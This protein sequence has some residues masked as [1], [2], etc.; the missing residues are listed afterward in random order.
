MRE[1][2][3][4]RAK[5]QA[6]AMPYFGADASAGAKPLNKRPTDEKQ[7]IFPQRTNSIRRQSQCSTW[8]IATSDRSM[9]QV[10]HW[11]A[12]PSEWRM[13]NRGTLINEATA[14]S[15]HGLIRKNLSFRQANS[16]YDVPR[17]TFGTRRI[18]GGMIWVASKIVLVIALMFLT[19]HLAV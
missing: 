4:N 1:F 9:F 17:G 11:T 7:P 16:H 5:A 3:Q 12:D 15:R 8:N 18:F 10:E 13:A 19:E 2:F 6:M 14:Q